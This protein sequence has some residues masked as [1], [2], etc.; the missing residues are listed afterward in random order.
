LTLLVTGGS[1]RLGKQLKPHFPQGLFPT[2]EELPIQSKI[3]VKKY[4]IKNH[5]ETIIHCAA[6]TSV[7]YCDDHREEAYNVNVFG[8]KNLIDTKPRYFIFISTACV[9]S[10]DTQ[11]KLYSESDIPYP[12]NFYALTKLLAEQEVRNAKFDTLIIRTNFIERGLWPYPKAFTDR[13]ATYLY[14]DQVAKE[15]ANIVK[16]RE[17]G[18]LHICGDEK[19]SMFEFAK[20]LDP[21]V[22]PMTFRD[23]KQKPNLTRNM[24]L[25]SERISTF[26]FRCE[27]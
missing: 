22:E 3:H 7:P 10:G 26:P 17:T 8:T 16:K 27:R 23:Y 2:K 11:D 13:Y 21:K 1:G 4:I 15:I 5:V 12:K 9:F 24:A 25:T 18:L 14:S 6:L 19:L 20:I